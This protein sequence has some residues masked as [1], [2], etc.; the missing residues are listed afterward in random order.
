M[1]ASKNQMR[2]IGKSECLCNSCMCDHVANVTPLRTTLVL[3]HRLKFA[4]LII[5]FEQ[6]LHLP[7][8]VENDWHVAL[9]VSQLAAIPFDLSLTAS[10]H[11]NLALPVGV[12]RRAHGL[13]F[14]CSIVFPTHD[15]I[16]RIARKFGQ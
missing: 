7:K 10:I 4:M 14:R 6:H 11:T 1:L 5:E 2:S 12:F 3:G 15:K 9:L 13:I 16:S 8:W